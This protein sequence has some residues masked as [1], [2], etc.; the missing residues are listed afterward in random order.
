MEVKERT[1]VKYIY[2]FSEGSAKM[3]DLLGGKGAN[4][5]E[6]WRI[7]LPVPPGFIITTEGCRG[8]PERGLQVAGL[9]MAG[10]RRGHAEAREVNREDLWR[11][12]E[13][14]P[15]FGQIRCA[16][17]HARDDGHHTEPRLKR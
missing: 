6:M 1:G 2:E 9:H 16:Y 14:P 17:I 13:S 12:R 8:I 4:L 5:A 11:G 15:R 10:C 7:G 3:R